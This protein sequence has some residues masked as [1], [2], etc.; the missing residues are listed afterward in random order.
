MTAKEK[1]IRILENAKGD[2]LERAEMSFGK[3]TE[4]Q[5]KEEWGRSGR[6]KGEILEG[7]R[8]ER[9]EWQAAYDLARSIK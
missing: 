9:K 4:D 8:E 6:T 5:L 2:N 7:Y 3:L 1:L